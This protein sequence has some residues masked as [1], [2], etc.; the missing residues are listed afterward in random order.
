ML[1]S[2]AGEGPE[3]RHSLAYWRQ[4]G[5]SPASGMA[6][7]A[8]ATE[9]TAREGGFSWPIA[10]ICSIGADLYGLEVLLTL[11]VAHRVEA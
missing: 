11:P 2:G 10:G 8:R 1:P 4:N 5:H 9:Q 3:T 7:S 6:D